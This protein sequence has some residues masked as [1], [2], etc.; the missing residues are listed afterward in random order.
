MEKSGGEE[1]V[2]RSLDA[3]GEQLQ[4]LLAG[5]ARLRAIYGEAA[6]AS[7]LTFVKILED[8]YRKLY[9]DLGTLTEEVGKAQAGFLEAE[10]EVVAHGR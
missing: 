7:D 5:A 9:E 6:I 8:Q 10:K 1:L 3:I 4:A 2:R